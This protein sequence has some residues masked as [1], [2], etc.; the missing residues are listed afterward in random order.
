M[1]TAAR[2]RAQ[3]ESAVLQGQIRRKERQGK[4][5]RGPVPDAEL[6]E[7][8]AGFRLRAEVAGSCLQLLAAA[9]AALAAAQTD[10]WL[11][12]RT[13][14]VGIASAYRSFEQDSAAW[15]ATFAKHYDRADN[16]RRMEA[17][18]GGRH[19]D[20]AVAW[21]VDLLAPIKAPPGFS[22][23]SDGLAVDF[24]TVES[25]VTYGANTDQRAAWRRTWLHRWL[26]ANAATYRFQPLA[27]EEWHWDWRDEEDSNDA[28]LATA[29]ARRVRA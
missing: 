6:V 14:S 16:R 25:R 22:N 26:V 18:V 4:R 23:H 1:S 20:A 12:R 3:F 10:D 11:A 28:L 2:T 15:R 24:Q 29:D 5:Q 19:G 21:F 7:V 8:E 17:M 9:R 13:A 27:S